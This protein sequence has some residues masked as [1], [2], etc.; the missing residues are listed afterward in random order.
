MKMFLKVFVGVVALVTAFSASASAYYL[1]NG[2]GVAPSSNPGDASPLVA[3]DWGFDQYLIAGNGTSFTDTFNFSVATP[4][5][6]AATANSLPLKVKALDVLDFSTFDVKFYDGSSLTTMTYVTDTSGS[7]YEGS[8]P[9]N[10]GTNYYVQ[11]SGV[12]SGTNGGLYQF[13]YAMS[14]VPLPAAAWLFGSGL[15]GLVGI[16]RRRSIG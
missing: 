2:S 13:S 12:T 15:L 11:V 5:T 6:G 4:V 16:A 8:G 10:P 14:P 7:Y 1:T 3:G 9:L